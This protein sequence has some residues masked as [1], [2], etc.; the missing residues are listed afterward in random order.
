MTIKYAKI[1]NN[2]TGVCDVG[3]GTNT[4]F[5]KSLGYKELDVQQSDI[6]GNWYLI[7]KCPMKSDEEKAKD[8]QKQINHLTCTA[9]DLIQ[10][11][12]NLGVTD[13]VIL[14]Y[15]NSNPSIQLQL[16]LC[17]DVYCGVVRQL[18]P[19]KI[20]EELTL[21]DDDIV[22]FFKQKYNII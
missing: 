14:Q 9:L 12:K 18:C 11:V 7:N 13:E 3:L 5:Y 6:D 21:T 17:K 19:I 4:K 2:E 15:L 20:T 16:T 10:F 22:N 1:R 8:E